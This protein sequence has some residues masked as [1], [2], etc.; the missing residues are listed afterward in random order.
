MRMPILI[1]A[2]ERMLNCILL[3]AISNDM[4]RV[5]HVIE[6]RLAQRAQLNIQWVAQDAGNGEQAT[7]WCWA[8]A[9]LGKELGLPG[10]ARA[11]GYQLGRWC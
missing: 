6:P 7:W 9:R 2:A 10:R 3:A 5:P 4:E 1:D 11:S 8:L